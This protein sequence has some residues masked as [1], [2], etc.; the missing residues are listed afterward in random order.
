MLAF[1][2]VHSHFVFLFLNLAASYSPTLAQPPTGE[3][4]GLVYHHKTVFVGDLHGDYPS[5]VNVLLMAGVVEHD[6]RMGVKWS[7]KVDYF[8]QTGDIMD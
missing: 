7:G 4:G 8:V 2:R 6:G 3:L 1:L 5:T